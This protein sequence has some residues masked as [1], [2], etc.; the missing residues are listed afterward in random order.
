MA[1]K[2]QP[3]QHLE[4]PRRVGHLELSFLALDLEFTTVEISRELGFFFCMMMNSLYINVPTG[5]IS[6]SFDEGDRATGT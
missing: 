1:K 3:Q 5:Y 2:K 6:A 4:N